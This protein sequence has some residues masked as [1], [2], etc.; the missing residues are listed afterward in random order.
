M[1]K[2]DRAMARHED[3]CHRRMP[4]RLMS[5]GV[6]PARGHDDYLVSLALAVEA[7]AFAQPRACTA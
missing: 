4:N 2:L 1:R 5:F 3:G 6:D 7:A